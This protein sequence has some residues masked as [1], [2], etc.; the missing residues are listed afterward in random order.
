MCLWHLKTSTPGKKE[1]ICLGWCSQSS[2]KFRAL[3]SKN[4]DPWSS[5]W[6]SDSGRTQRNFC[7]V[8]SQRNSGLVKSRFWM[9]KISDWE[10]SKQIYVWFSICERDCILRRQNVGFTGEDLV[11]FP[12]IRVSMAGQHDQRVKFFASQVTIL[13]RHYWCYQLTF[14]YFEPCSQY[15]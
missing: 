15:I 2:H 11:I 3:C 7:L 13:A 8:K 12:R 5:K 10:K 9:V 4:L 1:E 14:H 6:F